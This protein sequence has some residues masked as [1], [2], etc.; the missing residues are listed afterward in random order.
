MASSQVCTIP[1]GSAYSEFRRQALASLIGATDVQGQYIH[2]VELNAPLDPEHRAL[3]EKLLTNDR[4][5]EDPEKDSASSK[6]LHVVPRPGT[7]SPWS[8]KA[9]SIAHVCGLRKVVGRIERGLKITVS[10]EAGKSLEEGRALDFLHDRMTETIS[11]D[12]PNLDLLFLHHEP[13]QLVT[14]DLYNDGQS[15]IKKLQDLNTRLGLAL[16]ESEIQYLAEAYS[17]DGP[18]PRNPTDVEL[19]MFAQV[20][21]EHC[22]HKIFNASWTIDG[23]RKPN[24]LF[25]M[26]RNTHKRNPEGTISAY[27]DN[28][29]VLT[30]SH[31]SLWAPDDLNGQWKTTKE[32]VDFLIK[33][34]T[35]NHPTAV[36]PFP[37]AATGSGGEIR[38]EGATGR[39]SKPKAGLAGFCVSD[40]LIPGHRQ[41]WELDYGKPYHIASSLDIML[42][43]P[44]GSAAFNNEFGRPC[45]AGYFRTLLVEMKTGKE[46]SEIRGYHKPIMIAGGVGTVRPQLALKDPEIVKDGAFLIVMGG[47]AMLIGLGGGA[48]SSVSSGE[49]SAELDF[50]S[51]QRGNP[52]MQ[53]RAQEVINAC[54]ALGSHNPI[55]FIHDV[56]AGG[57]SNALPELVK[58]VNL[59]AEFELRD[60]DCADKS[61][62][63]LQIWCCEAQERYVLA[64]A[65]E[66]MN[67]FRSI[68]NRERC[69]IS[70]VGRATRR[71]QLKLTDRDHPAKVN[72]QQDPIDLPMEVLFGKPPKM[73]RDVTSRKVDLPAFDTTLSMYVPQAS[74]A[75][76]LEEAITRVLQMPAVGSKSFLI[77]IGDRTVGGLTARDQM[78]GPWQVPV[79]DVSV[80]ATSLTTGIKTGE[81]MAMGER[82]TIALISPTAS[83]RM[84]VAEALMNL[85]AAD[86]PDRLHQVKL[87]ANWMSAASHPGEGAGIYEAVE[88]LG[89][90]LCPDL[91]ISIPVGKDSMSMKM[92]WQDPQSKEAKEVTAP[93]SLVI[94]A[95]APVLDIKKT[96]TPQ[97]RRYSEVGESTLF[98][99]DL[100]LAHRSLGGSILAQSF[101][102]IG[103]EAP[104]VRSV[105]LFK[106]FFDA[107]QQLHEQGLVL[108]YHDRSDGGLFTTLAEMAFAGRCGIEIM[109]NDICPTPNTPDVISALFN[110]ELGAVFQVRKEDENRFKACFATC[111]PP[112]GLIHKIGR[113]STKSSSQS[114]AIYHGAKLI[115]RASR[116]ELQQKWSNTSYWLQRMRDNPACADAEYAGILNDADPGI[117]YNLTFNPK[118]NI[119]T[120]KTSLL[121]YVRPTA[122][123]RV[124]VLRDQGTN[125]QAEM[126]FAFD[127]A[128]FTVVDVHM[129][130][131]LDPKPHQTHLGVDHDLSSFT[132]LALAG[133]FSFGDCL[134]AGQGWAKSILFHPTTRRKFAD[135]FARKDTFTLGVCNGCQVLSKLKELIPGAEAWPSFERNE[136][137]QY[138]GRVAMVKISDPPPESESGMPP[139]VFFHG[140]S[141]SSLP[142]AVAHGEGRASFVTST[143]GNKALDASLAQDFADRHLAPIRFV[144]NKSLAPTTTY[145]ANPNGSP[146]GIAGVR[147]HDGRV[148]ALMPHPERTVLQGVGSYIPDGKAAEWGEYGPW[149]RLFQSARRWVG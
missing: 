74:T 98:F 112:P 38:D 146:A 119:N 51:V 137:E 77:T 40:L 70:V 59:G 8:S 44:I 141:G 120:Y 49:G 126:A 13:G 78:V 69:K 20:N 29:A 53:R 131:I 17:R 132:G 139:S 134:G 64:V 34:E 21:S 18:V 94:S 101:K 144:D 108:A 9:T 4:H 19:F 147:S 82:P 3:L 91:G 111:G 37:G 27:S 68:A 128:G 86:L 129:S 130:D 61:M 72:G 133:G 31:G 80:T 16:D 57:L 54:A 99:V 106:D 43:A 95:F 121:S 110:E 123:P 105:R 35:H 14:Y 32:Q 12:E 93:L 71:Q 113:V 5:V 114:M 1:G 75:G 10:L 47:P 104:D 118:E 124:A 26:I 116:G 125:G 52:E 73:S 50:A 107:T 41:P 143:Q 97:L 138:E 148:L 127:A 42:E 122:R 56:G 84:A 136:S 149:E 15:P 6:V 28:A 55:L 88:A 24:T 103:D 79:A 58:D 25:G 109:I 140:M 102:Q 60:I 85:T 36:S 92:K 96:W 46:S 135:F 22:R 83:A 39:G 45:T 87:S 66:G 145:P 48:A 62:S 11:E 89:M 7:I 76:L 30:G 90:D 100:G 115:Y 23:Q 63:P 117:S 2:Y 142:I 67:K 81:A 65:Q 33:V